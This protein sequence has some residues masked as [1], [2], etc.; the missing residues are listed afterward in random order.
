MGQ[1]KCAFELAQ[2]IHRADSSNQLSRLDWFC[3]P[4]C[5]TFAVGIDGEG[6]LA[7]Y[8]IPA[9]FQLNDKLSCSRLE[10]LRG[11]SL[12]RIAD[13]LPFCDLLDAFGRGE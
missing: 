1:L 12:Y 2:P 10:L 7:E 5:L 4:A 9:I 13:L 3:E 8:Q 11:T 6:L